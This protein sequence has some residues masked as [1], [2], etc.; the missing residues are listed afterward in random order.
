VAETLGCGSRNYRPPYPHQNYGQYRWQCTHRD[1][2]E[3][4]KCLEPYSITKKE[5]LRKVIDHYEKS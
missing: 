5:K 2:Y 3:V 1:A 4:A